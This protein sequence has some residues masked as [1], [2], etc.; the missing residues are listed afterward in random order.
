[1]NSL[2]RRPWLLWAGCLL[3]V[4]LASVFGR[5]DIPIDETRY[6]SVAWEMWSGGDWLVMHRN[7]V[8]YHHKPPLL[9]WLIGLGW[10]AR[11]GPNDWWPRVISALFSFACLGLTVAIAHRL[12]PREERVGERAGWLLLGGVFWLFFSTSVVFDVMLAAFALLALLAALRAWQGER[13]GTWG[14]FGV[15]IGL[16]ILAKGPVVL[17]DVLPPLLLAP[18]W[19]GRGRF[20][21][22]WYGGIGLGFLLGAGIA[23]AWAVPAAILGGE[24]FRNAIF[25]GQ[26]AGRVSGSLAHKQPFWFYLAVLPLLL[27]PWFFWGRSWRAMAAAL[28]DGHDSGVRLCLAW[29]VPALIVFSLAGGKQ[30]HYILPLLPAFALLLARG[31]SRAAPGGRWSVLPLALLLALIGAAFLLPQ[32]WAGKLWLASF[33]EPS[34]LAAGILLLV[35]A[36]A[37]LFLVGGEGGLHRLAVGAVALVVVALLLILKPLSPIFD[38]APL[39]QRLKTLEGQGVPVAHASA[40]NDQYQYYGRLSRPLEEI[41]RDDLGAWFQKHPGGRVVAYLKSSSRVSAVR[42]EFAQPYLDGAVVLLDAEAAQ[43]MP[44]RG[45]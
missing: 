10:G 35:M 45:Q 22:A 7:G 42:P 40:Y 44:G 27:F 31:W 36:A 41:G 11:G 30:A 26:T 25:W 15:A 34:W 5:P 2:V 33:V 19:G 28:R 12:W 37:S 6:V 3:L 39:A 32:A 14:L 13:R 24:E 18:W 16:G 1:M 23:L 9:F 43:R 17:L 21:Q 29:V 8:P 20:G 38:M 4:L